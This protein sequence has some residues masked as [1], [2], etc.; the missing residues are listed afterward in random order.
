MLLLFD[1]GNTH[2]TIGGLEDGCLKFVGRI[3]SDRLRTEDEYAMVIESELRMHGFPISQVEDGVI[4]SVVPVLTQALCRAFR[5]LWHKEL[6]VVSHTLDLGLEIC[7]DNPELL[8]KDLIVDAVGAKA[9]YP[10]PIIVCD[11]GTATTISV[12]DSEGRYRGGTIAPGLGL[13]VDALGS[14]TAQLPY[15]SL[16]KPENLV[17]TN[18]RDC[19]RSGIMHGHAAMIDG[20]I[21]RIEE[22]FLG[23]RATRVISGGLSRKIAPLCRHDME[24][25]PHLLFY[26]LKVIYDANKDRERGK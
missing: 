23:T 9:K 4:S 15:I 11:L 2:I 6:L 8:G 24:L 20:M 5:L 13:S 26:G 21:T 10:L 12:I 18:T 14:R 17:G 16:D 3:S 7:T 1:V 19:I 22:D 25:D